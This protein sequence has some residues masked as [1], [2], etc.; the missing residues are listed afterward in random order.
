[1]YIYRTVT[2]TCWKIDS[3]SKIIVI[4]ELLLINLCN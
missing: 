2:K 1:M 3:V 4:E